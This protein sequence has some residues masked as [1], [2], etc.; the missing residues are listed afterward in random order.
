MWGWKWKI[1]HINTTL[2]DLGLDMDT[3]KLN[4]KCYNDGNIWSLIHEKYKQH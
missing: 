4:I 2:I 1:D 3:D